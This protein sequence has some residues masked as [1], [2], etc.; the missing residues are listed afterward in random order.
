MFDLSRLRPTGMVAVAAVL[1]VIAAGCSTTTAGD[2]R[3]TSTEE[4][5]SAAESPCPV[6]A[7]E[8]VDGTTEIT[9]WHSWIGLTA[10]TLEKI[11]ADYNSSQDAVRVEVQAQGDYE[12]LLAKYQAALA[13]PASLPDIVIHETTALRFM[14]DSASAVPA[15]ACIEA[16]PTAADFYDQVLPAVTGAYTVEDQLWPAA[17]N[18][19]Q[20]V[21]YANQDHLAAAGLSAEDLPQTLDELR[22]AAEAIRAADI[23]GVEQPF[24]GLMDSWFFENQLTGIGQEMVDRSNGRDGL[25]ANSELDDDASADT[26]QWLA[27]MHDDGLYR[28]VPHT[29]AVDTLLALTFGTSSMLIGSSTAITSVDAAFSGSADAEELGIDDT[30]AGD[31]GSLDAFPVTVAPGPGLGGAGRGRV[32]GMAWYLVDGDDASVAASWDF[33]KFSNRPDNQVRWTLEGSYLPVS[34]EARQD[35][36]L[37]EAFRTTRGGRWL[38]IAA[39]SLEGIDPDFPGPVVGPYPQMTTAVRSAIERVVLEGEPVP[40]AVEELD[41]ALQEQLTAY[42]DEVADG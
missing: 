24:I 12:E 6:G 30:P 3:V 13:D 14:V 4:D 41:R 34:E 37:V 28:P 20:E 9:V 40:Q 22:A 35:P 19:A 36:E 10:A 27:S 11:A 15:E 25:A 7:H 26:L 17:F 18:V 33:I 23:P 8:T 2:A 16:D 21:L 1:V 39:D 38:A 31:A 5:R 32:G 29:Q 42:A